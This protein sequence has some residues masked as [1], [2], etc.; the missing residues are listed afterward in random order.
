MLT[1]CQEEMPLIKL[2]GISKESSNYFIPSQ[3]G[4]MLTSEDFSFEDVFDFTLPT[5]IKITD[6]RPSTYVTCLHNS[7]W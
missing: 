5:T 7:I 6:L 1:L 4:H 2:C 3:I